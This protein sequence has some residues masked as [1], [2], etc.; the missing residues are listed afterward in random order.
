MKYIRVVLYR[1]RKKM[2]EIDRIRDDQFYDLI[3]YFSE[4]R[5]AGTEKLRFVKYVKYDTVYII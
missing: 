4:T 5:G 2:N 1:L 3:V